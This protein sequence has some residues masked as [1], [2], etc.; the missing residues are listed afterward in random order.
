MNR[1][2]IDLTNKSIEKINK[3]AEIDIDEPK[4]PIFN[5][6]DDKSKSSP[7]QSK[8]EPQKEPINISTENAHV[9]S[10]KE[11]NSSHGSSKEVPAEV[12]SPKIK[13]GQN[14]RNS[15]GDLENPNHITLNGSEVAHEAP[16]AEQTKTVEPSPEES[17]DLH[18]QN[19]KS[20]IVN[21][22][23]KP[24]KLKIAKNKS[25]K[26]IKS[27]R[28]NPSKKVKDKAKEQSREGSEED[29]EEFENNIAKKLEEKR[30]QDLLAATEKMKY[31]LLKTGRCPYCTLCP[32]CK[33]FENA[34]SIPVQEIQ[35]TLSIS[36]PK[37]S[38]SPARNLNFTTI[39]SDC[40]KHHELQHHRNMLNRTTIAIGKPVRPHNKLRTLHLDTSDN[41]HHSGH[42]KLPSITPSKGINRPVPL[43]DRNL[44]LKMRIREKQGIFIYSLAYCKLE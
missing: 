38:R 1:I 26:S 29:Y 6:K 41:Y 4:K 42:G 27:N 36:P 39:E 2:S 32:P 18:A 20:E 13:P 3:K 31:K 7:A 11:S 21:I 35:M 12:E 8:N 14:K 28:S 40:S 37:K 44:K 9:E 10:S 5:E 34:D 33:H 17:D 30:K 43:D 23:T 24:K 25:K 22:S 19:E 16:E 15:G